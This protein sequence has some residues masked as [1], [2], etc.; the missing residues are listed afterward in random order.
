MNTKMMELNMNEM[1]QANGCGP[2]TSMDR[3][4]VQKTIGGKIIGACMDA[5][6]KAYVVGGLAVSWIKSW[7]D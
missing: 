4:K 1:E 5:G 6:K 7:F 2:Y 3:K